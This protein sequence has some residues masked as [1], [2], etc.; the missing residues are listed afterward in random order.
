MN[1][2]CD[3]HRPKIKRELLRE[4]E[5]WDKNQGRQTA[6]STNGAA[7]A[8]SIMHKDFNGAAWAASHDDEFQ[9]LIAK[10]RSNVKPNNEEVVTV[11]DGC[12]GHMSNPDGND[13]SVNSEFNA[14]HTQSSNSGK[15]SFI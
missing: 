2:N 14:S 6:S 12:T 10:A 9:H 3:S 15:P 13:T 1:A 4:L 5:T 11:D 8:S 7:N